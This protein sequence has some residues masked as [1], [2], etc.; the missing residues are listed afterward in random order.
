MVRLTLR[1]G[2]HQSEEGD[3]AKVEQLVGG[4]HTAAD[5][6][7]ADNEILEM[8]MLGVVHYVENNLGNFTSNL[9]FAHNFKILNLLINNW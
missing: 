5:V 9:S 8:W 7:L 4:E 6:M 3:A 2:H 1:D